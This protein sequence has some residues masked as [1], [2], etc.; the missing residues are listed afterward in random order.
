MLYSYPLKPTKSSLPSDPLE[1]LNLI[2]KD[3][4]LFV[5]STTSNP[6][7]VIPELALQFEEPLK[8]YL[9]AFQV[10][11]ENIDTALPQLFHAVVLAAIISY[12]DGKRPTYNPLLLNLLSSLQEIIETISLASDIH[13]SRELV[14]DEEEQKLYHKVKDTD[15][16]IPKDYVPVL[17]K[18]YWV[19]L[20]MVYLSISKPEISLQLAENSSKSLGLDIP[21]EDKIWGAVYSSIFERKSASST[22]SN[23]YEFQIY[24]TIRALLFASRYLVIGKSKAKYPDSYFYAKAAYFVAKVEPSSL[25]NV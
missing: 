12:S 9:D 24:K 7:D 2:H 22:S 13:N 4:R 11:G 19:L 25:E 23:S 1:L 15:V 6:E 20:V 10:T 14:T 5:S 18:N 16:V 21:D 17:V 3:T 8:E